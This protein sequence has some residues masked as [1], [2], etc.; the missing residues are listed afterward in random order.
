MPDTNRYSE[1]YDTEVGK[2]LAGSFN[3]ALSVYIIRQAELPISFGV[4]CLSNIFTDYSSLQFRNSKVITYP[5]VRSI[6]HKE[7]LSLD[8]YKRWRNNV[9]Q[10][11][12]KL[13]DE[14]SKY[15]QNQST[16]NELR[17]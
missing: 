3:Q 5:I 16:E 17:F 9:L 11:K 12:M 14:K 4:L 8:H 2:F 7:S 15:F 13:W 10:D 1:M 6:S